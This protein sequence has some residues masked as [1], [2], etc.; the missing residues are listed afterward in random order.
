MPLREILWQE[1]P[2]QLTALAPPREAATP[3][4]LVVNLGDATLA[5]PGVGSPP[6]SLGRGDENA[7]VVADTSASRSHAQITV[8]AGRFYISD[9]STNGTYVRPD[10]GDVLFVHR[11]EVLL[12]GQGTI[13]LG[14]AF[15]D[16]DGLTLE[17]RIG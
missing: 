17:Y 15:S 14:R 2:D 13:R 1:N 11:D 3:D 6:Q 9:H 7:L 4:D 10:G 16:P 12:N 8:R 5:L